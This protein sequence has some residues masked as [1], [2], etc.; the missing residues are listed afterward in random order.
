[1]ARAFSNTIVT[2]MNAP[3]TNV[4]VLA[5]LRVRF[6]SE[7]IQIVNNTES[8]TRTSDG[9]WNPY[10]FSIVLPNDGNNEIP[11]LDVT[12]ANV[13][14]EVTEFAK[15]VAGQDSLALCDLYIIEF[16]NPDNSLLTYEGYEVLNI[17][18]DV[19]TISFE[20]K[21]HTTQEEEL[22]RWDFRPSIFP[23]MF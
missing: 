7:K 6:G 23:A 5:L 2:A 16:G 4:V 12:A 17:R 15:R 22:S 18:Y 14:L 1:M 19:T 10:P 21:L 9:V 3:A 13:D 20:L 8:V 11:V